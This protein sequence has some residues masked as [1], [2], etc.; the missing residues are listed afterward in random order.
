MSIIFSLLLVDF[1]DFV[2]YP[3]QTIAS[4]NTATVIF[5]ATDRIYKP[6]EINAWHEYYSIIQ[7][8][9]S[10]LNDYC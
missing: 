6:T 1:L 10:F 4:Y 5:V 2:S 9:S 3:P 8:K 7:Q